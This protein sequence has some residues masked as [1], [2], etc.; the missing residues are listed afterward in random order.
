MSDDLSG[1]FGL[2]VAVANERGYNPVPAGWA[3]SEDMAKARE[4]AERLNELL[5]HSK[6]TS[7]QIIAS[8]M[9]GRL[10]RRAGPIEANG[11]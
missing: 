6:E 2:G 7:F 3:I 1:H 10:Y 5:G 4:E 8:T 9:G 11:D